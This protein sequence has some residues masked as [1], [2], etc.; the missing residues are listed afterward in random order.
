M[1]HLHIEMFSGPT[2]TQFTNTV[3]L[4]WPDTSPVNKLVTLTRRF[5]GAMEQANFYDLHLLLGLTNL[6]YWI[7]L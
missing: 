2:P 1:L 5:W 3:I 4:R 7:W 6:H